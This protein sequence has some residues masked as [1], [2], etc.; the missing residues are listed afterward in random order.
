MG[1]VTPI[2]LTVPDYWKN[3]VQGACG[4]GPVEG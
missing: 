3:L 1:A 4:I 2:G